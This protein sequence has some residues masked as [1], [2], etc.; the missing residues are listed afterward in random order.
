MANPI[1]RLYIDGEQKVKVKPDVVQTI[2]SDSQYNFIA[3]GSTQIEQNGKDVIIYSAVPDTALKFVASGSTQIERNDNVVTIFS[4]AVDTSTFLSIADFNQYVID[5][6]INQYITDAEMSTILQTLNNEIAKKTSVLDVENIVNTYLTNYYTKAEIDLIIAN[7]DTG[8]GGISSW[9]QLTDIPV[10]LN[11]PTLSS[12][13]NNHTHDYNS[14]RNKP[15][16]PTL[17][18]QLTNDT[19]FITFS[20]IPTIPSDISDL[21]D[22]TNLLFDKNYNSLSNK[23]TLGSIASK[24]IWEGTQAQYNALG[25]YDAN[26]LYFIN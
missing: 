19:K 17:L 1:L 3:S 16:I 26:T 10:W 7:I 6:N 15:I 21:S 25:T 22:N 18:S 9:N 12:F 20:D 5:L 11:H 4:P 2:Y 13:E 24:N 23:P 14:L 8:S